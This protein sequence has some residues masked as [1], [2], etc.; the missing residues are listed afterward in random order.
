MKIPYVI[1]NEQHRLA[2]V[3]SQALAE[4]AGRSLDTATAYF[5]VGGFELLREGLQTLGNF[6]LLLGE[7]PRSR[8]SRGPPA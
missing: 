8:R 2:A 4:S 3:L 1:D 6:R 5:T 7:E